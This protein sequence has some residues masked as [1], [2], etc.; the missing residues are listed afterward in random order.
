[1]EKEKKTDEDSPLVARFKKGDASAFEELMTRYQGR[2]Y[3][4][5]SRMCGSADYAK[6][7]TQ[8]S[9]LTAFRYLKNFREE[10]SFKTW[11]Y[12]IATTSCFRGKRK[13]K[14]EPD[15]HLS[16]EELM[17]GEGEMKSGIKSSWYDSPS[18]KLLNKELREKLSSSLLLL[19]EKYRLVFTLRDIEGFSADEVSKTLE[20][21]VAAVKSRLHRA[22][23]FLRKELAEYYLS[24]GGGKEKGTAD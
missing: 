21:S 18:D 19:P 8:E 20:I 5:L 17:P 10:A 7:M 4:F 6:D 23:L 15:R 16:L 9:F 14:H 2:I 22:R 24:D 12:R 1:M 13:R 11:M 3:N